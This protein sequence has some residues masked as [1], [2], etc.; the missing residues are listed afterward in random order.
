MFALLTL[1]LNDHWWCK[2]RNNTQNTI[3]LVTL[4]IYCEIDDSTRDNEGQRQ[5]FKTGSTGRLW[6]MNCERKRRCSSVPLVIKFDAA[7][8]EKNSH[9]IRWDETGSSLT[10]GW[11]KCMQN[12][13]EKYGSSLLLKGIIFVRPVLLYCWYFMAGVGNWWEELIKGGIWMLRINGLVGIDGGNSHQM[14]IIHAWVCAGLLE[15]SLPKS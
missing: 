1:P 9:Q 13:Y 15:F 12:N 11:K 2:R 8:C 14:I 5:K 6:E 4:I 10:K 7:S 3:W